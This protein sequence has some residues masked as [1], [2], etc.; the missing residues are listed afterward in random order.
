[1]ITASTLVRALVALVATETR[2]AE[3]ALLAALEAVRAALVGDAP[4]IAHVE[5]LVA[6]GV[7]VSPC[8]TLPLLPI[9]ARLALA[10]ARGGGTD[11]AVLRA[12]ADAEDALA[13]LYTG[14]GFGEA[15]A[16]TEASVEL[17]RA[18]SR[19]AHALDDERPPGGSTHGGVTSDDAR[20]A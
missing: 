4:S 15:S 13:A 3:T 8:P 18:C 10:V 6:R 19:H 12:Y 16:R 14:S 2:P 5:A 20:A 9:A 7:P 1:M 11:V 17:T